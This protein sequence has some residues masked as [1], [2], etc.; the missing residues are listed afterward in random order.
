MSSAFYLAW[1]FLKNRKSRFF[2]LA[3]SIVTGI[4]SLF[5]LLTIYEGSKELLTSKAVAAIGVNEIVVKPTYRTGLLLVNKEEKREITYDTASE[6]AA[7]PAVTAVYPNVVLQLP[8]S[9]RVQVF[10]NTFESDAPVFG[11][12]PALVASD[13]RRS[14]S[15]QDKADDYIPVVLSRDLVDFYNAG[16]ADSLG[17][18]KVDE[19]FLL[20]KDF[21]LFL[22]YSS[23]TGFKGDTTK[24]VQAKIV[25]LS[26][27]VPLFGVSVPLETVQRVG[28]EFN[29]GRGKITALQVVTNSPED[30]EA[31]SKKIE[32]MGFQADSLQKRIAGIGDNL[33]ALSLILGIISLVILLS[34]AVSILNTFFS[35][36]TEQT[37]LIG[38]LRSVG[39]TKSFIR[40]LV[41]AKAALV[42]FFAGIVGIIVGWFVVVLIDKLLLINLPFFAGIEQHVIV[43]SWFVVL[44]SL[45]FSVVLGVL[46]TLYPAYYASRLD[47]AE[48]LRY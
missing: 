30:V 32:E 33:K 14:D 41:C 47:P 46:A 28:T 20:D 48:S 37:G 23:F 15:F 38:I 24:E 7:I 40:I 44:F 9:L 1:Q 4:A 22:G 26:N 31:V 27:K 34:S 8:T 18:P 35:D 39:A 45:L 16:F 6:L 10:G 25:G 29:K 17:I 3:L 13:L 12:A 11:I 21:T 2:F 43:P 5:V 42:S 36:V 19:N